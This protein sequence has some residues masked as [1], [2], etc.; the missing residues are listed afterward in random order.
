MIFAALLLAGIY[1]EHLLRATL[2]RH[3][4]LSS[5]TVTV[6]GEAPVAVGNSDGPAITV[7]LVTAMR[8]P[9]GRLVLTARRQLDRGSGARISAELSRRLYVAA[10][11]VEPDPFVPGSAASPVAQSLVDQA[12]ASEPDLVT[13][14]MH[15]APP[16]LGNRI[17][18]SSFGRIGKAGDADDERIIATGIPAREITNGSKRAAVELPLLDRR[19]RTIG[20]LSLSFALTA[21][22]DQSRAFDRAVML[23]DRLARRIPSL[24]T[25]ATG[26]R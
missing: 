4:E 16:G 2:V 10:N 6:D 7:P 24:A 20:A 8:E 19:R 9:I 13:I 15:V 26:A 11:L 5:I 21:G 23:R 18:A 17:I 3:P 22:L 25:L 1:G 14:A 12:L